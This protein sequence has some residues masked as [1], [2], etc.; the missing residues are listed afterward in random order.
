MTR[1]PMIV[2]YVRLVTRAPT[3]KIS[4]ATLQFLTGIKWVTVEICLYCIQVTNAAI[5]PLCTAHDYSNNS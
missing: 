1:M 2:N 5:I 3:I 4:L